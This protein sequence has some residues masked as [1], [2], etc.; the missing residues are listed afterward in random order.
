MGLMSRICI[1]FHF[2][3]T[4][5]CQH[6]YYLLMDQ[7]LQISVSLTLISLL[8]FSLSLSI[9]PCK[10]YHLIDTT[11]FCVSLFVL[12]MFLLLPIP[13]GNASTLDTPV[14]LNHLTYNHTLRRNTRSE[15]E[16]EKRW[17]K[18]EERETGN[19]ERGAVH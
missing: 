15:R 12:R 14:P 19:R 7:V 4:N 5:L 17:R 10:V 18:E 11:C 1:L 9:L 2:S 3:A 13:P 16:R 8:S 6:K